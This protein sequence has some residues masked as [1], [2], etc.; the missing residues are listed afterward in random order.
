MADLERVVLIGPCDAG[1]TTVGRLLATRLGLDFHTLDELE[2]Q[3][4]SVGSD[5]ETVYLSDIRMVESGEDLSF[6][7]EALDS[8]LIAGKGLRNHL[9]R[10]IPIE[11]GVGCPIHL[12]HSAST[13][14]LLDLVGA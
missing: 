9:D 14:L 3:S 5:L 2:H 1:K 4:L 10:H 7:L 12:A 13:E 11:S 8:F 6:S